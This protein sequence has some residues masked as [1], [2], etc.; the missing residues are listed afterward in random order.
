[1]KQY[2]PIFVADLLKQS[3]RQGTMPS[4]TVVSNSM[5]SLLRPGDQ[6]GLQIVEL[7]QIRSGHI[8]TFSN[9]RDP[10]DLVIH[11]VVGAT[12][13]EEAGKILTIG[14]RTLILDKL[15]SMEDVV[16]RMI[17]RRRNGRVLD[18]EVGKGAWL[19]DKLAQ[20]AK[21]LLQRIRGMSLD[22]GEIELETID[23]SNE[24][25]LKNGGK[26]RAYLLRRANYLW[27]SILVYYADSFISSNGH[28]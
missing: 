5:S 23:R 6:V 7:S 9:P 2:E 10:G 3:I 12:A 4:L 25:C 15:V 18:L 24:L 22:D 19:S 11:R 21:A 14:D 13:D 26:L 17:W 20:Q 28:G 16:G 1:M 27:A 8:V